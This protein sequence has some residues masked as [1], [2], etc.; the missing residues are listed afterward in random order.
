[1]F[2]IEWQ[3]NLQF[4]R[5]IRKLHRFITHPKS[6]NCPIPTHL[7]PIF[8]YFLSFLF[9]S[10]FYLKKEI[11]VIIAKELPLFFVK[12]I[13]PLVNNEYSYYI[14]SILNGAKTLIFIITKNHINCHPILTNLNF[15]W[16]HFLMSFNTSNCCGLD[17]CCYVQ[18]DRMNSLFF[19]LVQLYLLLDFYLFADELLFILFKVWRDVCIMY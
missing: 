7:I 18:T 13:F 11:F 4:L 6:P 2:I 17:N 12:A 10:W 8:K 3:A 9:L 14:R 19:L 15:A 5:S 1:M 16:N